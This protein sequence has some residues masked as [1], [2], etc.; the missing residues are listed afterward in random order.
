MHQIR[1]ENRTDIDNKTASRKS[2]NK[3]L[4]SLKRTL[5]KKGIYSS[6]KSG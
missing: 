2:L 5:M 1:W 6:F 3:I 4:Y